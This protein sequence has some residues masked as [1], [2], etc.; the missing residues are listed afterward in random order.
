MKSSEIEVGGKYTA[1][2]SGQIVT[3]RV[4][5]I[6]EHYQR[7][8]ERWV[9]HYECTNLN[10]SRR[11]TIKS[12]QRF[13]A[14]VGSGKEDREQELRMVA[15]VDALKAELLKSPLGRQPNGEQSGVAERLAAIPEELRDLST[16]LYQ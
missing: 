9:D 12:C 15:K 7:S 4:D 16:G 3:V 14:K 6:K 11:I 8:S 1:K 2:V 10:T 5:Q 13:R